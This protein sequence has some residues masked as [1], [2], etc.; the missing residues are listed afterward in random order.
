MQTYKDTISILINQLVVKFM[1][2]NQLLN[3]YQTDENFRLVVQYILILAFVPENMIEK[4]FWE[5]RKQ[6]EKYEC[7]EI[8]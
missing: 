7:Y 2:K 8:L 4:E 3:T 1:N 6:K 5:S